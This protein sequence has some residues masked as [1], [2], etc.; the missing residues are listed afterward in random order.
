MSRTTAALT[1]L[2]VTV[3]GALSVTVTVDQTVRHQ[4]IEGFGAHGSMDVWWHSGP[5][6]NDAFL[7][8]VVDSIGLTMNRNQFYPDFEETNEN[9]NPDVLDMQK[10]NY[11]GKFMQRQ[12][13]WLIALKNKAAESG[14][15]MRFTV[16]YWTPPA[17]MKTNNALIDG[18]LRA[19]MYDEFVE[20]TEATVRAYREQCGI[21]L[22]ALS[23]ENEPRTPH[24]WESCVYTATEY[25]DLVR[26]AG[27]HLHS[28]FP[29]LKLFGAEDGLRF[30]GTFEGTLMA[31][32]LAR[33]HM[34]ALAVH[35]YY[36][37]DQPTPTD[38]AERMYATTANRCASVGKP[39]WMTE[40]SGYSETWDDCLL[41]ATNTLVA[42]KVG[43]VSAWMWWSLGNEGP[44]SIYEITNRGEPARKAY[45]VKHFARYIRPGAVGVDCESSDSLLRAVAF[46]HEANR[47]LTVVLV[48]NLSQTLSARIEADG[49]TQ[50]SAYTSDAT[51]T[52][53]PSG[54]VSASSVSLAPRSVV[55]LVAHDWSPVATAR[56]LRAAHT[57]RRQTAAGTGAAYDLRGCRLRSA[58][59]TAGLVV[60]DGVG[61]RLRY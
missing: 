51:R 7:D 42:L 56:P 25:R 52:C 27:P 11:N 12:K 48:N 8:L 1:A 35:D 20:F 9:G 37:G 17:W 31:D 54:S 43:K 58:R 47:T 21:E 5:F 29:D 6:Y 33:A 46:H 59:S 26:M 41:L 30:F 34:H 36:G 4:T 14:E 28:L 57:V 55:T 18:S 50:L 13:D 38:E 19:D 32:S 22:Y 45:I 61:P 24:P 53:A 40:T 60:R 44:A 49:V 16:A 39:L 2:L 10:F 15:P 23:L 3:T